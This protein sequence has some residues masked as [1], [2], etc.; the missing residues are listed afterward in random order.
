[1]IFRRL[2]QFFNEN[3]TIEYSKINRYRNFYSLKLSNSR[4]KYL[5]ENVKENDVIL[6]QGAGT[7][8]EIGDLLIK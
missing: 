8:T 5:K 4:V 2:R 1:M 3:L 7:V 6:T